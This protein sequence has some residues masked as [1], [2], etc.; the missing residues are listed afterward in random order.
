MGSRSLK[1]YRKSPQGA[2]WNSGNGGAKAVESRRE[3]NF[4]Y[5]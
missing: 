2:I 4:E 3:R 5:G 1:A